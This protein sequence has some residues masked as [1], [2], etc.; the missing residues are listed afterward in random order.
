MLAFERRYWLAHPGRLLAGVDEVGRGP[1]AG[2]VVAAAVAMPCRVAE[3]QFAGEWHAL[4]D[5]KRLSGADRERFC[6][7]ILAHPEITVGLG[8][9][10]AE[11]VDELNVLYATYRAMAL[12]LRSLPVCPDHALVDGLPVQGLP[13]PSQAVVRGD[14]QSLLIA[15]ASVVAKVHRD[16][17][18]DELGLR[19]PAYGFRRNKGYGT[20]AHV[21][22]LLRV[23]PCPEHRR[24][25]RPVAESL[26]L[27]L[28]MQPSRSRRPCGGGSVG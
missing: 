9:V 27:Q 25:F 17:H 5:S 22:A 6:A 18:M 23:G 3:R 12:A 19:Y 2:P 11:D 7:S 28:S 14:A 1:L 20:A 16:R 13:C 4:T 8:W 10:S 21:E 15:A 24:S 26:Q